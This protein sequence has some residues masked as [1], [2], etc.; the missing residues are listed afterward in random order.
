MLGRLPSVIARAGERAGLDV[1]DSGRFADLRPAIELGGLD[2]AGHRQV[3]RRRAQ[4]LADGDDVD[5][6]GGEVGLVGLAGVF[7]GLLLIG[8]TVTFVTALTVYR[9]RAPLAIT[10]TAFALMPLYSVMTH[11]SDNEQRNHY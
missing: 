4:V 1:A 5:A 2:P 11:W 6:D 10:L 9:S 7:A 8:M 3:M